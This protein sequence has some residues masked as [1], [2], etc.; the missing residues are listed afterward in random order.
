MCASRLLRAV[1]TGRFAVST[2]LV[3]GLVLTSVAKA[4]LIDRGGGL[5]YDTGLNVTWL[6]NA[7]YGFG[8]SYD[9]ADGTT[10]GRMTW[11]NAVAWAANL[12]YYDRVR[13]VTYTDWRLPVIIDTGTPGCNFAYSG[14]DCGYNVDTAT[15]ELA[16]LFYV[17]LGDQALKDATGTNQTGYGLV[18]VGPFINFQSYSYWSGTE[19][20]PNTAGS[21]SF[22]TSDGSQGSNGK[23]NTFYA[24]AVMPGDVAKIPLPAPVW[25]LCSGL[26]GFAG[27]AS[28]KQ[29]ASQTG[30]PL[31]RHFLCG[32]NAPF[33]RR[34]DRS[35]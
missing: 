1:C 28:R 35:W 29:T 8:S 30:G 25:L 34:C 22:N 17:D 3:L 12:S 21:W 26:L 11:D 14:T 23:G 18:N 2:V 15:S 10:D 4:T 31:C 20:A 27:V 13:N 19:Y 5:L 7:D 24:L 32:V 33:F 6:V 9:S 16:Y